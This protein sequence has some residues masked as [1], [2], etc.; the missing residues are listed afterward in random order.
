MLV[1]V[2][3][4]SLFIPI[5][6][7]PGRVGMVTMSLVTLMA[8]YTVV[9]KEVPQVSYISLLDLWMFSSMSF[10]V[11]I[12]LHYVIISYFLSKHQQLKNIKKILVLTMEVSNNSQL[13]KRVRSDR[14]LCPLCY[15]PRATFYCYESE[16]RVK[17]K[18]FSLKSSK[19]YQTI[20]EKL[21]ESNEYF[22]L[23]ENKRLVELRI[24]YLKEIIAEKKELQSSIAPL[25]IK[26]LQDLVKLI[27]PIERICRTIN[28][29]ELDEDHNEVADILAEAMRTSF[30]HGRWITANSDNSEE[31]QY[32]IVNPTLPS[33]GN[34]TSYYHYGAGDD[35]V[36]MIAPCS[37]P[38]A[39]EVSLIAGL[40]Y[41]VQLVKLIALFTDVIL[42][43]K[44]SLSDFHSTSPCSNE[45][46]FARKNYPDSRLSVFND[47]QIKKPE[48]LVSL[49][50]KI[51]MEVSKVVPE[52][53]HSSNGEECD[54]KE[55][56]DSD[57]DDDWISVP[58][59][60]SNRMKLCHPHQFLILLRRSFAAFLVVL[61]PNQSTVNC[62][63]DWGEWY[64]TVK[65]VVI[66][67]NVEPEGLYCLREFH[68]KPIALTKAESRSKET[69]W[70]G[71]LKSIDG[72]EI[73]FKPDPYVYN[74]MR[75]KL[76]LEQFQIENP[77]MNFSNAKLDK[78][79]EDKYLKQAARALEDNAPI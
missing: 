6:E 59:I 75:K 16:K 44:I 67:V 73:L 72:E 45:Y 49:I 7:I 37:S 74:E 2:S 39:S 24:R 5:E 60:D 54:A 41:V 66:L 46:R 33:T 14:C 1:V 76:D 18:G 48:V 78:N 40:S 9:R 47:Q 68:M 26:H 4:F 29:D 21:S 22:I 11:L 53:G 35:Q 23:S 43:Q 51:F 10:I 56:K 36:V 20:R 55:F 61:P 69:S 31:I 79:Y 19:F 17:L 64:Q 50:Q 77:G 65:E 25:R 13:L 57:I 30:V 15:N 52:E 42:P 12:L 3:W 62:K 38:D 71:L 58:D 34:Y 28:K 70:L 27:F 32:R 8:L 63:T